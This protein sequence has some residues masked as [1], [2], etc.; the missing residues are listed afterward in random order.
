MPSISIS[1]YIDHPI[2]QTDLLGRPKAEP[3]AEK[4]PDL[5]ILTPQQQMA[6][7]TV[8]RSDLCREVVCKLMHSTVRPSELDYIELTKR[9]LIQ[10]QGTRRI[11]TYLGKRRADR[12][13]NELARELGLHFFTVGHDRLHNRI[14]CTCGWSTVG[15]WTVIPRSRR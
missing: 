4:Q 8:R 11:V 13:A 7:L 5:Y 15:N 6:L 9:G 1:G 14:S 12:I 2:L 3:A 10:R